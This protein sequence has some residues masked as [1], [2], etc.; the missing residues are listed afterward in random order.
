VAQELSTPALDLADF[1]LES[2]AERGA[3]MQLL[4]PRDDKARGLQR[5]QP[6]GLVFHVL[7]EDSPTFRRN[8]RE[9]IDE[10]QRK[11]ENEPKEPDAVRKLAEARTAACALTGWSGTPV[12]LNGQALEFS[13]DAAAELMYERPWI[14]TQVN[15]FRANAGNFGPR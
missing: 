8:V 12:V 13:R 10:V 7:G 15:N 14:A 2:E 9:T 5:G 6:L 4:A 11:L 3:D 1:D